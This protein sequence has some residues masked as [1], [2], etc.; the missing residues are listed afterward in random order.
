MKWLIGALAFSLLPIWRTAQGG[1]YRNLYQFLGDF[2]A[3][4]IHI[5]YEEAVNRAREAYLAN[6]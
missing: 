4:Q 3:G 1:N 2:S 5:P 6:Q